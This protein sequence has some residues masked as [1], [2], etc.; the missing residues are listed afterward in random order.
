VPLSAAVAGSVDSVVRGD[1]DCD[2]HRTFALLD[3][4]LGRVYR[5]DV[6]PVGAVVKLPLI[7]E[8]DGAQRL[9][10]VP[11]RA[12]RCDELAVPRIGGRGEAVVP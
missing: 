7:A 9:R 2:G 12:G 10:V 8:V 5:S 4:G 1:W 11:R 6:W 3:R